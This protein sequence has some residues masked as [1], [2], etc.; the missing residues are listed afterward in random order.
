VRTLDARKRLRQLAGDCPPGTLA[1]Y[2]AG[3]VGKVDAAVEEQ[4]ALA[5]GGAAL[6]E[7]PARTERV[8][9]ELEQVQGQLRGQTELGAKRVTLASREEA[10]ASELRSLRRSEAV[11]A[12]ISSQLSTLTSQLE[13]LVAA[14]GQLVGS[15]GGAAGDMAALASELA[16]LVG[17]LEEAKRIV[18][19]APP[20][21]PATGNS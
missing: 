7:P 19:T 6:A 17:A 18:A 12:Q 4:W 11:S 9:R 16:S 20:S 5:R 2:L 10:L 15:A 14:A 3:A 8:T 13:G 21:Q 1:D